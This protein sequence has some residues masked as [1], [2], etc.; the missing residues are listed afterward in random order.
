MRKIIFVWLI[1]IQAQAQV[2][3]F[4]CP[5]VTIAD[6]GDHGQA[7]LDVFNRYVRS[8]TDLRYICCNNHDSVYSARNLPYTNIISSSRKYIVGDALREEGRIASDRLAAS[9]SLFIGSL[10][11]AGIVGWFIG[12]DF[13][14]AEY[15]QANAYYFMIDNPDAIDQAI[16][17]G[18]W[19]EFFYGGEELRADLENGFVDDNLDHIIFVKS[20]YEYTSN[21]TPALAA[22]AATILAD[23]PDLTPEEL[24]IEL[25]AMT[26]QVTLTIRDVEVGADGVTSV[27]I[28]KDILAN[29]IEIK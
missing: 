19:R 2:I 28:E 29:V 26:S 16:F 4:R 14:V 5:I 6:A 3:T 11:N 18:W 10:E 1:A 13:Y 23:N 27:Q 15:N 12:S 21:Q 8:S 20:D 17:V 22:V 25:F 7:V 9:K 24:K